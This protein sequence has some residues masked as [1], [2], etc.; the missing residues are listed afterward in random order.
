MIRG[1]YLWKGGAECRIDQREKS[2]WCRPTK[3]CPTTWEVLEGTYIKV[4]HSGLNGWAFY[5]CCNQASYLDHSRKDLLL[6]DAAFCSWGNPEGAESWLL[7]VNSTPRSWATSH[8][9]TG[10]LISAS[11]CPPLCKTTQ[12]FCTRFTSTLT[13]Y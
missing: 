7:T 1:P 12:H 2:N 11:P 8:S 4:S 5:P 6:G 13:G 10:N 3:P 9:L